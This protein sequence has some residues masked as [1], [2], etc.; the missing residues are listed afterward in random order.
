MKPILV[1]GNGESRVA[2]NLN[3]FK[4]KYTLIGCNAAYR[5]IEVD[6]LVCCDDRMIKEA[7]DHIGDS[8]IYSRENL[9]SLPYV[10]QDR[11]DDPI[12]W[13]SGPYAVLLAAQL[14]NDINLIGFDLYSKTNQVNNVYKDTPNYL[15]ST[16]AAV[17]YSYWMYQ[18]SKVFD[19]YP[20]TKFTVFNLS[21]WKIP[22]N[23]RKINVVFK[24][25]VD[26]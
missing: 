2:Y 23:W 17:D 14:S 5:D 26:L 6:Y 4:E 19:S 7:R 1:I 24:N 13:G 10:G 16:Q 12:H 22:E 15:S 9:P 20:N 18:L 25:I 8:K 21:D 11:A 3:N